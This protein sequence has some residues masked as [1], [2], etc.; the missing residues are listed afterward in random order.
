VDMPGTNLW[1]VVGEVRAPPPPG[2]GKWSRLVPRG[3]L[4]KLS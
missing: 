2:F 1:T 4:G 3:L